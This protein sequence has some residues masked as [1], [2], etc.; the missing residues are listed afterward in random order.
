[1]RISQAIEAGQA[2]N[3]YRQFNGV[4]IPEAILGLDIT[5]AAKLLYRQLSRYAGRDGN[6]YPSYSK[7]AKDLGFTDRHVSRVAKELSDKQLIEI[8][9]RSEE[10]GRQRSNA[11]VFLW[12]EAFEAKAP[13]VQAEGDIVVGDDIDV[14]GGEDDVALCNRSDG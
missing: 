14:G 9:R 1:M 2:F 12:H 3:P 6:A 4:F 5:P 13:D 11:F 10:S 7:L 8:R